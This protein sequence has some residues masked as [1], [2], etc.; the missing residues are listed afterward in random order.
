MISYLFSFSYQIVS[1]NF[2][3]G[4]ILRNL[5]S[6]VL[7]YKASTVSSIIAGCL[8]KYVHPFVIFSI[9][10][11]FFNNNELRIYGIAYQIARNSGFF[12]RLTRP[13]S[14]N[15]TIAPSF[16]PEPS[17]TIAVLHALEKTSQCMHLIFIDYTFGLNEQRL[18]WPKITS[19]D[20]MRLTLSLKS[21]RGCRS[22]GTTN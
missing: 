12:R 11:F 1:H 20:A 16:L 10:C 9:P 19:F 4:V 18:F 2:F 21:T 22:V 17:R 8:V 6:T 5:Y 7:S 14:T 15:S 13:S 3:V